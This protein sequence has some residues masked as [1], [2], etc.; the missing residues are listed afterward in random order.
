MGTVSELVF[1]TKGWCWITSEECRVTTCSSQRW[2]KRQHT[3]D[4]QVSE[5]YILI[6]LSRQ[7]FHIHLTSKLK[8][9]SQRTVSYPED[10]SLKTMYTLRQ[11]TSAAAFRSVSAQSRR[12]SEARPSGQSSH[13]TNES[14]GVR[15]Y[16]IAKQ[17]PFLRGNTL[18][19]PVS[20]GSTHRS[21]PLLLLLP[22]TN[23]P[24]PR[25]MAALGTSHC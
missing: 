10:V 22:F 8:P 20:P 17:A 16:A 7:D 14:L 4:F 2:L 13:P 15:C 19:D 18:I 3:R 6:V 9:F 12:H 24:G 25:L 5:G 11:K 1:I 23:S 21:R